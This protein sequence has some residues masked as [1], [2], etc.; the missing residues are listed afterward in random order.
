MGVNEM[1]KFC[2]GAVVIAI[3][4]ATT[5]VMVGCFGITDTSNDG[6]PLRQALIG[7]WVRNVETT[8]TTFEFQA[9]GEATLQSVGSFGSISVVY[10]W[11]LSGTTLT[12]RPIVSSV[13]GTISIVEDELRFE[14]DW[15]TE[16]GLQNAI[17][18]RST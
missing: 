10:Q 11:T 7:T 4:L 5:F 17:F 2:Y 18:Q 9:N 3:C 6:D 14:S 12:L 16:S 1:K 8:T 13:S 15:S